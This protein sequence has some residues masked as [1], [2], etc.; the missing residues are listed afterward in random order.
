MV[1][2]TY[3]FSN[4]G[5]DLMNI[6][7]DDVFSE[8]RQKELEELKTKLVKFNPDK[9]AFEEP[10]LS[11]AELNKKYSE[12]LEGK[13]INKFGTS[14][15]FQIV[16]RL[17]KELGYTS[18]HQIDFKSCDFSQLQTFI[19]TNEPFANRLNLKM[20]ETSKLISN[21]IERLQHSS[22]SQFLSFLN[23]SEAIILNHEFYSM[24]MSFGSEDNYT[25]PQVVAEW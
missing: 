1:L 3:H 22:F 16:F 7:S 14:E 17:A 2:G 20:Q 15:D 24:L 25:G 9:I 21:A 13:D 5:K 4:P 19:K 12:Y 23:S 10:Y 6:N 18:V 11:F 8:R